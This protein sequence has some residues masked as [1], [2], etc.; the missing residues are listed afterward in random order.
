MSQTTITLNL[1]GG[2][3]MVKN[4]YAVICIL[5]DGRERVLAKFVSKKD[6]EMYLTSVSQPFGEWPAHMKGCKFEV[7]AI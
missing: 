2:N 5:A 4:N 1:K 6:A 3:T 7:R